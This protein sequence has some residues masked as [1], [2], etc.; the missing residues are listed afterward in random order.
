MTRSVQDLCG[1]VWDL[2]RA[3]GKLPDAMSLSRS[4]AVAVAVDV[5][6]ADDYDPE[7]DVRVMWLREMIRQLREHPHR[8]PRASGDAEF[9]M[10]W[11]LD[12]FEL[13]P[14]GKERSAGAA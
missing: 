2:R 1:K 8:R 11:L 6:D 10:E 3:G 14:C 5:E 12:R 13:Q 9:R 4:L 7:A